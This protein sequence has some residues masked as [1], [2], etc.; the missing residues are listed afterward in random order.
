MHSRPTAFPSLPLGL[1]SLQL[2]VLIESQSFRKVA[3]IER[4]SV[5]PSPRFPKHEHFYHI[6]ILST[7][8]PICN[9]FP[10]SFELF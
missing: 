2:F 5:Y 4:T 9:I 7:Y 1:F 8:L 6:Y 10:D 3:R